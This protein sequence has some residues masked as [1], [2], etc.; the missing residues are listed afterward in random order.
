MPSPSRR[1]CNVPPNKRVEMLRNCEADLRRELAKTQKQTTESNQVNQKDDN[2][3]D[4]SNILINRTFDKY[5]SDSTSMPGSP[6]L[7]NGNRCSPRKTH[8]TNFINQNTAP[9]DLMRRSSTPEPPPAKQSELKRSPQFLITDR[10]ML[11]PPKSPTPRR[12][13]RSQSPKICI[14]SDTDSDEKSKSNQCNN[15]AIS[16]RKNNL[17]LKRNDWNGNKENNFKKPHRKNRQLD[18]FGVIQNFSPPVANGLDAE[19]NKTA[20]AIDFRSLDVANKYND[21]FYCPQ[22]EPLKRKIY[23]EKTLDRLQKSLDMESGL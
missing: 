19:E 2:Y 3:H 22:S 11:S 18:N 23:S 10:R 5:Q 16:N 6:R 15:N 21:T 14:E 1:T 9:G 17:L 7:S 8:V 13:F 20:P 4:N 12:R